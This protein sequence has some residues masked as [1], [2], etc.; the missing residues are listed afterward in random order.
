MSYN[1]CWFLVR[2]AITSRELSFPHVEKPPSSQDRPSMKIDAIEPAFPGIIPESLRT[3]YIPE[4]F[5]NSRDAPSTLDCQ[6]RAEPVTRTQQTNPEA[7]RM[8]E[9]HD[10]NSRNE[11]RHR[12]Q[13]RPSSQNPP[14]EPSSLP[15]LSRLKDDKQDSANEPSGK[16]GKICG[17]TYDFGPGRDH[18]ENRQTNPMATW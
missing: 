17:S 9:N 16:L 11:P 15:G 2:Q 8:F 12:G 18:L 3:P 4:G 10:P 6:M 1:L 14:N 7:V 13:A 5:D